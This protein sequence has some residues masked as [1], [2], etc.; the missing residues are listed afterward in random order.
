MNTVKRLFISIKQ[1]IENVAEDFEDHQA[2]INAAITELNEVGANTQIQLN[3]IRNDIVRYEKSIKDN[4]NESER[5]AQR[6]R[7][8]HTVD[9]AKALDC[10]KRINSIKSQSQQLTEQID[11]CIETERQLLK[12]LDAIN[13][14]RSELKIRKDNLSSREN[15]T[16]TDQILVDSQHGVVTQADKILDRWENRVVS[17]EYKTHHIEQTQHQAT[18]DPLEQ[19]FEQQEETQQLKQMLDRL[20]KQDNPSDQTDID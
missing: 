20:T 16:V 17:K 10:M 14:K 11:H 2:F 19:E 6:A 3:K 9:E 8:I 18:T 5:W 12:D 1:Q 4:Q 7:K 13:S 15:R